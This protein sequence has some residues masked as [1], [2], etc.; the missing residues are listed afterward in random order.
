[1]ERAEVDES[2]V[3]LSHPSLRYNCTFE[4]TVGTW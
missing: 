2:G 3:E 1:M 4:I